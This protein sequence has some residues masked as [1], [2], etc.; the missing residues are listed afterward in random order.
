MA[1]KLP[2]E[3][4]G[5]GNLLPLKGKCLEDPRKK[6][7][8]IEWIIIDEISMISYE[9]LRQINIRTQQIKESNDVFGGLNVILMGD[10]LQLKPCFGH[11][12]FEQPEILI[13][14]TNLWQLFEMDQLDQ[15]QRQIS[16]KIYGDLCSRIRIGSQ[17]SEDIDLLNSR[18]LSNLKNKNEFNNV[19]HIMARKEDVRQFN[20]KMSELLKK[21]SK[22]YKINAIDT[23]AD[24]PNASKIADKKYLFNKEEKCG[25][26]IESLD[27]AIGTR[28]MLRRN[29]DTS[30]GIIKF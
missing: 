18:L 20:L 27:I 7:R 5:L 29:M 13:H 30:K 28:I 9:V 3:K 21:T 19:L 4:L 26:L 14:E 16:D 8:H 25:G 17:T 15:N 6:W 10:L 24:G 22:T 12:I 23:Y 11:W 2:I 1:F